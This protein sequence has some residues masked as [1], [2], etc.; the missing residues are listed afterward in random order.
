MK[1]SVTIVA[2]TLAMVTLCA[3][4]GHADDK[5]MFA[6]GAWSQC[7]ATCGTGAMMIREVRCIRKG[8]YNLPLP[9]TF[10]A[11][12]KQPMATQQCNVSPCAPPTDGPISA[13]GIG[14]QNGIVA[15]GARIYKA[16][17]T[18]NSA[19]TPGTSY[20]GTITRMMYPTNY[21]LQVMEAVRAG[22][23]V[24][25]WTLYSKEDDP[26]TGDKKIL[27]TGEKVG[28]AM[29]NNSY[30][31]ANFRDMANPCDTVSKGRGTFAITMNVM[32]TNTV[33]VA[34]TL[35][36]D[37]E[38]YS[39]QKLLWYWPT[40][41]FPA[42]TPEMKLVMNVPYVYTTKTPSS[43]PPGT[44]KTTDEKYTYGANPLQAAKLLPYSNFMPIRSLTNR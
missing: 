26:K 9:V 3:A 34:N 1:I 2:L 40:D 39:R 16:N 38:Y 43:L 29:T 37:P 21:E 24:L 27:Y 6:T 15:D 30:V 35:S 20:S 5:Y 13:A 11:T 42:E 23:V 17:I 36:V 18:L 31:I 14:C 19:G 8:S 12:L 28:Q 22:P 25:T 41:D 7:S 44:P 33:P 32:T 10:C 4:D